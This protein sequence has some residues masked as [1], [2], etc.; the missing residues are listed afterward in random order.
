MLGLQ[1]QTA[2]QETTE[3]YCFTILG[4]GSLKSRCQ[5]C[6]FL[7]CVLRGNLFHAY[8][9]ASGDS[10]RSL[11]SLGLWGHRS[12]L[13]SSSYGVLPVC[14]CLHIVFP[15]SVRAPVILG[16]G[17]PLMS[18]VHLERPSFQRRSPSQV[19]GVRTSTIQLTT[20][21]N[22]SISEIVDKIRSFMHK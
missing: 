2:W 20:G 5:H 17:P 11:V 19:L 15:L 3:I 18:G 10:L 8:I 16:S 7:P 4:T 12:D 6:W 13:S 22:L 14:L 9:L 1:K 21:R